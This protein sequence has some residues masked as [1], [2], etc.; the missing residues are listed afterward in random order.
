LSNAVKIYPIGETPHPERPLGLKDLVTFAAGMVISSAV[1]SLQAPATAFAGRAA[2]LAYV[3]A[4]ILGFITVVPYFLVTGALIYK[5]GDYA[6]VKF[7]FGKLPSGLYIWNY[8]VMNL[9]FALSAAAV[10]MYVKA[11]WPNAPG[12]II[13][14]LV[15]V[16]FFF[17]NITP[18]KVIK[19]TQN[20]MFVL[21]MLAF[22]VYIVYGVMRLQPGTFNITASGY[23][24]GGSR[25]FIKAVT[26]LTFSTSVYVTV[27]NLG[28]A[29]RNPRRQIP[30]AMVLAAGIIFAAYS[31]MSLVTSNA[32]P[33]EEVA[34]KTIIVAAREILPFGFFVFFVICGPFLA[35][36]TT[37]NAGFLGSSRPFEQATENGWFPKQF[38][39][40]NR[41]GSPVWCV[42]ALFAVTVIP[43]LLTDD[44]AT[45]A[46]SATMVQYIVKITTLFAAWNIPRKFPEYW[47]SGL[48]GRMPVSVFYFIMSICTL[49]Q[50]ALIV[51]AI[52]TLTPRQVS[53]SAGCIVILSVICVI[54]FVSHRKK[55]DVEVRPEELS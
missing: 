2:W 17:L 24:R 27:M 4:V 36:A 35:V 21:L 43:V 52:M 22:A 39:W 11:I 18:I 48:F 34:G 10:N 26:T 1:F 41:Y 12:R 33:I 40:K 19:K 49:V 29:S 23:F 32:L 5:G 45:I 8:I 50:L 46:N 3:V 54:W 25:G 42:F 31:L 53:V 44:V 47:K 55:I 7:G 9:A 30:L 13:S 14:I 51:M 6:L 37:L 15:I 20:F 28:P 38:A 16:F